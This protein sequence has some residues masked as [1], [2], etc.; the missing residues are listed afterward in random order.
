MQK[1]IEEPSK[2][3]EPFYPQWLYGLWRLELSELVFVSVLN[4]TPKNILSSYFKNITLFVVEII[5]QYLSFKRD[6]TQTTQNYIRNLSFL[7]TQM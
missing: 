7:S 6:G 4:D 3:H 2:K 5:T 1:I